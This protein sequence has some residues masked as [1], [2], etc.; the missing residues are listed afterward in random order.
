MTGTA[1]AAMPMTGTA[2]A[3]N[4]TN[5]AASAAPWAPLL[6]A[7]PHA[8]W[9]VDAASLTI[10]GANAA[11]G[12]LCGAPAAELVGREVLDFAATPE[13]HAFWRE[14][15]EGR[16]DT[17][18]SEAWVRRADGATT[19]V[20]R[21]AIRLEPAV[22]S[23]AL[24][25]VA[26]EDRAAAQRRE[27]ELERRLAELQATLDSLTE[28]VL[29]VDL[30]GEIRN[31]NRR[32]ADLWDLPDDTLLQRADDAVLDWM[33]RSVVDPAGYMRRLAFID[34]A[35]LLRAR[36][37]VELQSGRM[38][39]RIAVPQVGL[40]RPIGRVFTFRE[41]YPPGASPR[42]RVLA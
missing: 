12:D 36:D 30:Q 2:S 14:A 27:R 24:F 1:S 7:L 8:V 28:G 6:Q 9:V 34:D 31:F 32:F 18:E 5:G 41:V 23:G 42:P 35:P 21:R 25:V 15:A 19:P 38:L 20:T 11:A 13:D 37:V 10:V 33:R 22:H 29:V 4:G 39:E 3:A 17:I 26:L 40:G 16:A